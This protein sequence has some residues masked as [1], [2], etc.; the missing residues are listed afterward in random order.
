MKQ[1]IIAGVVIYLASLGTALPASANDEVQSG[2]A[3]SE[4]EE[5]ARTEQAYLQ[6]QSMLQGEFGENVFVASYKGIVHEDRVV[7]FAIWT[8]TVPTA[9]PKTD[10]VWLQ[11]S[12]MSKWYVVSWSELEDAV[13]LSVLDQEGP[14][15]YLTPAM[16]PAG[17]FAGFEKDFQAPAGFPEAIAS[18]QR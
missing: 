11:N 12:T 2:V 16:M 9:L 10:F 1:I 14:G 6:Q 8:D 17:F 4:M 15:R 5:F 7:S 13:P 18:G 3:S